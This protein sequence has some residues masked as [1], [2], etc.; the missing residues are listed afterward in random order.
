MAR[1]PLLTRT[2][3]LV[4]AGAL[5]VAG[6]PFLAAPAHAIDIPVTDT[7]DSGPGTLR[8]GILQANTTPGPDQISVPPGTYTVSSVIP[9]TDSVQIVGTGGAA[10]TIIDGNL[11]DR[12]FT[13]TAGD[14]LTL[15]GLTVQEFKSQSTQPGGA[16]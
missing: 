2:K 1:L 13:V 14:T 3:M 12:L 7:S 6:L 9:V 15:Q 11:S 10:V 8:A 4:I 16:M 5:G